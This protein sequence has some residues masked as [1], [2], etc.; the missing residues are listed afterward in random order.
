VWF[1]MSKTDTQKAA[2]DY[3][4]ATYIIQG[5]SVTLVNGRAE[6][7]IAGS[8]SKTIT[9]YFGNVAT[10]DLSGDGVP[11]V[12]FLLT[13]DGGGSGTFYYVVVAVND[14]GPSTGAD[15]RTIG[16]YKG[17]NALFLGDRIAPQTT[18]IHDGQ[19]VVNYAERNSGEPMTAQPSV[20]KSIYIHLDVKN[21]E[22]VPEARGPVF[23]VDD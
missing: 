15:T 23:M 12:A 22:L 3:K 21:M 18:E 20:G 13:Q 1:W 14:N 6:S 4:N 2:T 8:A 10:G 9:Q 19:L 17:T 16:S 11:D 5:Q 7:A